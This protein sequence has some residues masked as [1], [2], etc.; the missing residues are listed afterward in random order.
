MKAITS[1]S[2]QMQKNPLMTKKELLPQRTWLSHRW[3]LETSLLVISNT[4]FSHP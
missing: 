2:I 3:K 4:H 1:T